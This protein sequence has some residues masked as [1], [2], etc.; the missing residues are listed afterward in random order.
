MVKML[1]KTMSIL[2]SGDYKLSE[3]LKGMKDEKIDNYGIYYG[4]SGDGFFRL[5]H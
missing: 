3:R 2:Q 5:R 1:F 4:F